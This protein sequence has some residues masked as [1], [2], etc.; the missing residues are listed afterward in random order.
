MPVDKCTLRVGDKFRATIT[1][2]GSSISTTGMVVKRCWGDAPA[3][4][5]A[6]FDCVFNL[7]H[8]DYTSFVPLADDNVKALK[9]FG[10]DASDRR[11]LWI[12][13]DGVVIDEVIAKAEA[14]PEEAKPSIPEDKDATDEFR[15]SLKSGER[16]KVKD[17]AS[18][19]WFEATVLTHGSS[20]KSLIFHPDQDNAPF[21]KDK[22]LAWFSETQMCIYAACDALG[23]TLHNDKVYSQGAT[24]IER[25]DID[26]F[27][28]KAGDVVE[29]DYR[30]KVSEATTLSSQGTYSVVFHSENESW[31]P[32]NISYY[33]NA[34]ESAQALGL[35]AVGSRFLGWKPNDRSESPTIK[36]LVKRAKPVPP[37]VEEKKVEEEPVY[38]D[39]VKEDIQPGDILTNSYGTHL[40][41]RSIKGLPG[42]PY[43]NYES[44]DWPERGLRPAPNGV[45]VLTMTS[46]LKPRS[47][48][49]TLPSMQQSLAVD[50][51]NLKFTA[52]DRSQ[53]WKPEAKPAEVIVGIQA[54]RAVYGGNEGY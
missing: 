18:G 47:W 28:L 40:V 26:P 27:T 7:G 54:G 1:N 32:T 41:L 42:Q 34:I 21:I 8:A 23:I 45:G 52:I 30:G 39:L 33:G 15:L 6:H 53:R 19:K 48:A 22:V 29:L 5:L 13:R 44:V 38:L 25:I 43:A 31:F 3:N 11:S 2:D 51:A 37:K 9:A 17:K 36:R 24:P 16:I 49:L 20:D 12:H 46:R 14:K 50:M 4:I 35:S 10:F